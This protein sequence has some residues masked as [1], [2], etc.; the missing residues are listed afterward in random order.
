MRNL[1]EHDIHPI[2]SESAELDLKRAIFVYEAARLEAEIMG[3]PI[4]PEAWDRRDEAFRK[5]FIPVVR[6]LCSGN[7]FPSAEAAHNSW[8]QEY[9]KMGWTYGPIRDSE[10]KIHPDMVPFNELPKAEQDKDE[11]FLRLCH[12]ARA[13]R[14]V[15]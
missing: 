1:I 10:K 13:I 9:K 4:V 3:R 15:A 6:E 5:Q 2:N 7:Q 12:V 8:W 11:I 14:D